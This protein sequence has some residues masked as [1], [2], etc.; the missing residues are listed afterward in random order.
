[1]VQIPIALSQRTQ[2]FGPHPS[3][4]GKNNQSGI[5]ILP[6]DIE[7]PRGILGKQLCQIG[8]CHRITRG[9]LIAKAAGCGRGEYLRVS[10]VL[11]HFVWTRRA[12][13][14][15]EYLYRQFVDTLHIE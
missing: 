14:C 4:C 7:Q 6:T 8:E 1:M 5:P 10:P 13:E 3:R 12:D 2:L 15:I 9:V 11:L